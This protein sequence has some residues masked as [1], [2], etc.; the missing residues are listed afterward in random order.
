MGFN[1]AKERR[2]FEARWKQLRKQYEAAGMSEF[3]IEQIYL[4]DLGVFRSERAYVNHTQRLPDVYITDDSANHSTLLQ[5]FKNL[6][7]NF[8]ESEFYSKNGWI[9]TIE[10]QMLLKKL[11]Q[12]SIED[13]DL[14]KFI[15]LEGHTQEELAEKRRCSQ[16]SISK[17]LKKLIKFLQ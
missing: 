1:Y 13:L 2:K 14:L 12:L 15:V 5:K 16:R 4:F 9:D 17:R 3:A 7:V 6:W 8:D 11:Q 10:N